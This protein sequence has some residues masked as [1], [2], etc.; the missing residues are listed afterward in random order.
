MAAASSSGKASG[1][2]AKAG[3]PSAASAAAWSWS[4][5]GAPVVGE[6]QQRDAGDAA[7]AQLAQAAGRRRPVAALEEVGEQDQHRV[8]G[9]GDEPLAVGERR[10]DVGAAAELHAEE[11]VDGVGDQL[12]EVDDLGVEGDHA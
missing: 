10:A 2:Q 1:V 5:A 11:Q 3:T 7:A 4:K 6:R 12:G 8:V 9:S